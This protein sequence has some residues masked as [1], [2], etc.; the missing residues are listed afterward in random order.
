[1][2]STGRM[3]KRGGDEEGRWG[4]GGKDLECRHKE[5]SREVID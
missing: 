3:V 1:M 5:E 2:R 4:E